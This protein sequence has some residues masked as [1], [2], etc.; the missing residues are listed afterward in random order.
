MNLPR[1]EHCFIFHF[2]NLKIMGDLGYK[3]SMWLGHE[4]VMRLKDFHESLNT[5][6]CGDCKPFVRY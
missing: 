5:Y 4:R 1:R 3:G 2:V 6:E